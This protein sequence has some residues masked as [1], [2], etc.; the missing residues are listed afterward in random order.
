MNFFLRNSQSIVYEFP[1]VALT[2]EKDP[3]ASEL[4]CSWPR[5]LS[6]PEGVDYGGGD[7][8]KLVAS[9][10]KMRTR[11]GIEDHA[12][13]PTEGGSIIVPFSE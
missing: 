10:A 13:V 12:D 4:T 9:S 3:Q 11:M 7:D 2:V 6:D 5:G 8:G 1:T